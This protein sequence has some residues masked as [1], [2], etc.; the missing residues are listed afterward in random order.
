MIKQ[1]AIFLGLVAVIH[2]TPIRCKEATVPASG[3]LPATVDDKGSDCNAGVTKCKYPGFKDYE[4]KYYDG[5]AVF[6]CGPCGS[7]EKDSGECVECDGA[8]CNTKAQAQ[9]HVKEF[10]CWKWKLDGEKWVKATGTDAEK[11]TTCKAKAINCIYP[12]KEATKT[13][14]K[15]HEDG[16]NKNKC[17]DADVTAKKC[18]NCN[19]EKCSGAASVVF[20]SVLAIAAFILHFA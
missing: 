6:G 1:L 18:G 12:G 8:R 10:K 17:S 13:S 11:Y 3:A 2:A 7:S 15:A 9:S 5:A 19:T 4:D 14:F 16:C 20:S